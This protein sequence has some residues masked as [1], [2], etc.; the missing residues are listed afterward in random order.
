MDGDSR[1]DVCARGY[2]RV[3]CYLSTGAGFGSEV[4]GPIVPL[5][6]HSPGRAVPITR[7]REHLERTYRP[8]GGP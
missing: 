6:E 3:T 7:F 8:S 2:Y 1:A 4:A 5:Q